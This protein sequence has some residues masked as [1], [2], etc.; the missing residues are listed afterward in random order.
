MNLVLSL[1]A[2]LGAAALGA[3]LL[4]AGAAAALSL[5]ERTAAAGLADASLR[6]GDLT[7][8]AERRQAE[9]TARRAARLNLLLVLAWFAL[10]VA[11]PVLDAALPVYAA[12]AVLWLLPWR[13]LRARPPRL[14]E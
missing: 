2:V 12:G 4:R 10:L 3:R 8:L 5:A 13:P 6:R 7:G 1:L 9:R 11:P 14:P